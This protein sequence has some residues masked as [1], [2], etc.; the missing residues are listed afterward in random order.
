MLV[1]LGCRVCGCS[2]APPSQKGPTVQIAA[3]F[4]GV[5]DLQRPGCSDIITAGPLLRPKVWPPTPHSSLQRP[6][7]V[8][9]HCARWHQQKNPTQAGNSLL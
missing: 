4:G 5:L 7:V 9:G 6:V 1:R 3:D 2:F 8:P